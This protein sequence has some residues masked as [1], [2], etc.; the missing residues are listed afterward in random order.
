MTHHRCGCELDMAICYDYF[1]WFDHLLCF[2]FN[3]DF[4][5]K[6][7][8]CGFQ[9][10]F[11]YVSIDEWQRAMQSASSSSSGANELESS[12]TSFCP[13]DGVRITVGSIVSLGGEEGRGRGGDGQWRGVVKRSEGLTRVCCPGRVF[14]GTRRGRRGLA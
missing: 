2:N 1:E 14:G 3:L 9:M 10:M 12:L 11:S 7:I 6:F 8:N 4:K 5:P 13:V